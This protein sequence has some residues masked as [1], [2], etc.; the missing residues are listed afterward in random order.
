MNNRTKI[1]KIRLN[2]N[3]GILV[4]FC[5]IIGVY[6]FKVETQAVKVIGEL[7]TIPAL[8]GL[9]VIPIWALIDN[10][11][12]KNENASRYVVTLLI[13]LLTFTLLFIANSYLN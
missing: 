4:Y 13:T 8:L 11:R 2:L 10:F 1:E 9:V 12:N 7:L 3:L 6:Y 5:F